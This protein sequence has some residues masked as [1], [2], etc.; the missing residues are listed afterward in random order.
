[1]PTTN[2]LVEVWHLASGSD[3]KKNLTTVKTVVL[4]RKEQSLT[5][6]NF[7][8][9]TM[10]EIVFRK[11]TKAEQ[12]KQENIKRIVMCYKKE[13]L[14]DHLRGLAMNMGEVKINSTN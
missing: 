11:P 6:Q 4:L 5:E 7:L 14:I 9:A 8:K 10:G 13:G 3:A 12:Q 2:N 1:L